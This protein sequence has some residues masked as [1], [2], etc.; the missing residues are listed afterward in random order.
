MVASA[1]ENKHRRHPVDAECLRMLLIHKKLLF[2]GKER[3]VLFIRCN[4]HTYSR[5]GIRQ[6]V[7]STDAVQAEQ[8]NSKR[9]SSLLNVVGHNMSG[10]HLEASEFC[11]CTMIASWMMIR[12][13]SSAFLQ[14]PRILLER[15]Q[16][17]QN[18]L[19]DVNVFN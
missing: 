19:Y 10:A 2:Q 11:T 18:L 17:W 8:E 9:E 4:P 3:P 16:L 14:T 7:S 15:R 1:D 13:G 12:T 5:D 6:L